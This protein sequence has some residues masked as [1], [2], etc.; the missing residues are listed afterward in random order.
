MKVA[1]F[2]VLDIDARVTPT[3]QLSP[4]LR[5]LISA[6]GSRGRL[7]IPHGDACRICVLQ[8]F[9]KQHHGRVW[10][11]HGEVHTA[12]VVKHHRLLLRHHITS[13][14]QHTTRGKHE[15]SAFRP[16][17]ALVANTDDKG[18]S[19]MGTDTIWF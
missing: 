14:P 17:R 15:V 18:R 8:R 7:P 10:L 4:H 5:A 11:L 6:G 2:R 16:F 9:G 1:E 3:R 19:A 12:H 13:L